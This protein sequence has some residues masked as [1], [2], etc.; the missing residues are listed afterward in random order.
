MINIDHGEEVGEKEDWSAD[1]IRE[2]E[3]WKGMEETAK[4]RDQW[5]EKA[6]T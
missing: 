1:R 6:E 3:C 4:G 2:T 5:R